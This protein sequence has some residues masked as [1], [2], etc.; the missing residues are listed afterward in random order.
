MKPIFFTLASN[1]HVMVIPDTEAH[2]NGHPLITYTYSLFI[3][4]D[5]ESPGQALGKES[6]LHLEKIEDPN[7]LGF[8]AFEK[9]ANVFSYTRG[10]QEL[11]IKEIEEVIEHLTLI[12]DNPP[13]WQSIDDF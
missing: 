2:M 10:K 4:Q 8:V 3:D 7:Y 11:T 12:R 9:P 5:K 1:R 13:L 6:T